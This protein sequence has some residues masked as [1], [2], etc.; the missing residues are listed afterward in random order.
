MCSIVDFND[1]VYALKYKYNTYTL[2]NFCLQW[3]WVN[4]KY[5]YKRIKINKTE[6][7]WSSNQFAMH[8]SEYSA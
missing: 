8:A 7:D 2:F 1:S 4:F 6:Q 3:D 5:C